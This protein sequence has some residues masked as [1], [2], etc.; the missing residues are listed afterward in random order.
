MSRTIVVDPV[1]RVEGHAKITIMLD[2]DGAVHDA[3]FHVT[4]FRGFEKFC[5]GRHFQE[6]PTITSRICG[7][8]PV[9]HMLAS[10]HAGDQILAVEIPPTAVAL[11]RLVNLAQI[12]Q[13][14]ALSFFHL[15]SPDLLLGY[16]GDPAARSI[17]GVAARHPEIARGG[18]RLRQFGQTIIE[19]LAGK[20]IHPSW[21]VAGGVTAPLTPAGRERILQMLPEALDTTTR[22]LAWFKRSLQEHEAEARTFGNF[23]TLFLGMVTPDGALECYGGKLRFVDAG[24]HIVA[25]QLDAAQ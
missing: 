2:D 23:P 21:A 25:D 5:E 1:S 16:D 12:A 6:M 24:G 17:L 13:S 22:T 7:I 19:V 18:I 11:R 20:R 14:H 15:T 3:R 9:S 4:E 8:C 10:A